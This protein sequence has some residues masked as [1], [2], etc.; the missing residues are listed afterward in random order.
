MIFHNSEKDKEPQGKIIKGHGEAA[1]SEVHGRLMDTFSLTSRWETRGKLRHH[2]WAI[3][4]A[5]LQQMGNVQGWVFSCGPHWC[6][7]SYQIQNTRL[8]DTVN[9]LV[10]MRICD[11]Y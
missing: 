3:R 1:Q 10:I 6:G 9:P 2:L 7:L 8:A 5:K 11:L 4:S